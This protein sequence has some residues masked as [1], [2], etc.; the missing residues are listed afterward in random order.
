MQN[1][2]LSN[3]SKNQ[4]QILGHIR[5]HGKITR[6]EL[7]EASGFKLLTVT[8]TV[9]RFLE[10]GIITEAGHEQST[11]GRKATLLSINPE[12]RYTLAVDL[13]ASGARIGVVGMDGSVIEQ[14]IIIGQK[15]MP[16]RH[17]TVSQL[18]GILAGL[19]EKFGK[20]NILGLGIGISGIVRH[21]EGKIVMC[22]NLADWNDID[23]NKEFAEPLGVPVLADTVARCMARAEHT[24]GV[25]KGL[26]NLVAVSIGSSVSAGIIIN[27]RLYRGADEAAGE[28]GHTMVRETTR[29]C[30]CG[31]TGCL[32]LY[33]TL[34]MICKTIGKRLE[35]FS[36]YSPLASMLEPGAL[37]TPEQI[38]LALEQGDR[39]CRK[40]L[41]E[42]AETIGT[43][44]SYLANIVNP[45]MIVLGGRTIES[46]PGLVADVERAVKR[47]SFSAT[48]K[49]LQIRPTQLQDMAAMTGAAL[50]VIDKLFQ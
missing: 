5:D 23:V 10:D 6:S 18:R 16:A 14:Q 30:T 11:G 29:R 41:D 35:N 17:V 42:C 22:P 3:Y 26:D 2:I 24:I 32:E 15:Q 43:A 7:V 49:N 36:G 28:L 9:A 21:K 31:N 39:I 27:G 40:V 38:L 50:Q 33:V 1:S 34:A 19:I 48:Q 37:P 4:I 47:R 13:G 8:K 46:F 25:G 45:R 20:E 44:V 12:F